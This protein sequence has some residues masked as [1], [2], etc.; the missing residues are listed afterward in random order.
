[1]KAYF[2]YTSDNANLAISTINA[3]LIKQGFSI[4]DIYIEEKRRTLKNGY[5]K[6]VSEKE[7]ESC[8]IDSDEYW[9]DDY[10]FSIVAEV[11]I[12]GL[13]EEEMFAKLKNINGFDNIEYEEIEE[14]EEM[15]K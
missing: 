8:D 9:F 10:D 14:I 13:S 2:I 3:D 6:E 15:E 1:M 7:F 5:G 12:P 4:N 11:D